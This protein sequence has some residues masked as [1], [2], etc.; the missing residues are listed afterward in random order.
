MQSVCFASLFLSTTQNTYICRYLHNWGRTIT[1]KIVINSVTYAYWVWLFSLLPLKYLPTL[2][3]PILVIRS[4]GRQP[5]KK[6][7]GRQGKKEISPRVI[8]TR[9]RDM[10]SDIYA[11][12]Q[13]GV[14]KFFFFFWAHGIFLWIFK[15]ENDLSVEYS[16]STFVR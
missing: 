4:L 6:K 14:W 7:Q 12:L 16:Q 15:K 3:R 9:R 1:P 10:E 13:F 5:L 11:W 2:I 8:Y